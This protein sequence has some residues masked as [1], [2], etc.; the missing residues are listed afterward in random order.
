LRGAATNVTVVAAE[1]ATWYVASPAL[2]TVTV[3]VPALVAFNLLPT[4]QQLAVP[5]FV[6]P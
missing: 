4:I 1:I 3:Q 2:V 5:V 6:T